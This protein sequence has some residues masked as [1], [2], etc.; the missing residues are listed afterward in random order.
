MSSASAPFSSLRLEAPDRDDLIG[1]PGTTSSRSAMAAWCGVL[2]LVRSGT[3][4]LAISLIS[5]PFCV[6][7]G[8]LADDR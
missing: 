5:V 3:C 7:G 6:Y 8:V 1:Y 2:P 4:C